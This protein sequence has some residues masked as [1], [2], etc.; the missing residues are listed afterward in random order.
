MNKSVKQYYKKIKRTF[1]ILGKEEK[2]YLS[3]IKKHLE[4][5]EKKYPDYLYEDYINY[6]GYPEDVVSSYYE[7]V[8]SEYIVKHM[9]A[10]KII[11]YT[12]LVCVIIIIFIAV[13]TSFFVYQAYLE[14]RDSIIYYEETIIQEGESTVIEE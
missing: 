7:H 9:K 6:Y 5:D 4:E 13:Y 14:S 2:R 1:P 3:H 12:S 10:R 11:K 8:E